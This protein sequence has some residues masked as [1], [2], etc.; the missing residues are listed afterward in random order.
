[1]KTLI[2]YLDLGGRCREALDFYRDCFGGGVDVLM[3]CADAGQQ[4]APGHEQD[5]IHAEFHSE[6]VRFMASDGMPG[7]RAVAGDGVQLCI[8]LTDR[9]EQ[10]RIF[11]ALAAGGEVTEPLHD[12]FWGARFGM[13]TDRYGFRWM[14]NCGRA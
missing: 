6:A 3:T 9:A 14:F 11:T 4:A 8:D 12:A 7:R 5:V 2:P 13:L 10:A 1:M